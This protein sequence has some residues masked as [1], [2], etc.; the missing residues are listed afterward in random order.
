VQPVVVVWGSLDGGEPQE[1]RNVVYL[2]AECLVGWLEERPQRLSESERLG[3]V[4]SVRSLAIP[5]ATTNVR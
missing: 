5:R 2:R 3:F 4:A 1:E